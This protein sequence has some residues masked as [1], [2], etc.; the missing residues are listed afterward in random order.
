MWKLFENRCTFHIQD[1][2]HNCY[3]KCL[4]LISSGQVHSFTSSEHQ[5]TFVP[6]QKDLT[7]SSS[8]SSTLYDL[9]SIH[10]GGACWHKKGEGLVD[11]FNCKFID[12][13]Y[14]LQN[15]NKISYASCVIFPHFISFCFV[16]FCFQKSGPKSYFWEVTREARQDWCIANLNHHCWKKGLKAHLNTSNW[17]GTMGARGRVWGTYPLTQSSN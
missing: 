2:D 10:Q 12:K 3:Y 13:G 4:Y 1:N 8:N 14:I 9:K 16:L 11:M 6:S 7:L 5:M 17:E 15:K